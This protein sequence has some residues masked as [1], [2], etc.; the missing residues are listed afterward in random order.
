MEILWL[1]AKDLR[2]SCCTVAWGKLRRAEESWVCPPT[3]ST[4]SLQLCR[5]PMLGRQQ[6]KLSSTANTRMHQRRG[7]FGNIPSRLVNNTGRFSLVTAL[8][9]HADRVDT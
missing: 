4:Y 8:C 1:R 2:G 7:G 3:F 5:L 9:N 6:S